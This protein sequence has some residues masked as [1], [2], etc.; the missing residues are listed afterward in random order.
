MRFRLV[1]LAWHLED[2]N[3]GAGLAEFEHRRDEDENED[4]N[5]DEDKDD[6]EDKDRSEE[7]EG[8]C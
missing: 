1:W 3:L 6:G 7:L 8:I 4:E 2:K 5:K